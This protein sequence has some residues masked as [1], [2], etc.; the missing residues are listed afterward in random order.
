MATI[1]IGYLQWFFRLSAVLFMGVSWGDIVV[2]GLFL[3]SCRPP[4]FQLYLGSASVLVFSSRY[5]IIQERQYFRA[6]FSGYI[7][8]LFIIIFILLSIFFLDFVHTLGFLQLPYTQ[9]T[10][11]SGFV[12]LDLVD[13]LLSINLSCI[14]LLSFTLEVFFPQ[15]F[16][17]L[18]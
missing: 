1:L 10:I 16:N 5:L 2:G 15:D 7:L 6:S 14:I 18:F 17:L 9:I 13:I 11:V 3:K 4:C 12:F 8:L